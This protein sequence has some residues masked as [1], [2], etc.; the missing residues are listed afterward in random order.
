M[1]KLLCISLL[2]V[3]FSSLMFGKTLVDTN[4]STT[5]FF[6]NN[7]SGDLFIDRGQTKITN[8]KGFDM[9]PVIT[10]NPLTLTLEQFVNGLNYSFSI[11]VEFANHGGT[12]VVEGLY[13]ADDDYMTVLAS[14]PSS[15]ELC[16]ALVSTQGS[17]NKVELDFVTV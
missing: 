6:E 4:A 10:K 17:E 13:N 5:I 2:S 11:P 1:N 7:T 14:S 12:C 16:S 15:H 3:S 9:K 8:L